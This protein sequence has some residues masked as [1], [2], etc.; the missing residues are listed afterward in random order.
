MSEELAH[1]RRR[2]QW[3]V[4]RSADHRR[5]LSA[6][7]RHYQQPIETGG[8]ILGMLRYFKSP[9]VLSALGTILVRTKWRRFSK[10]PRWAWSGW[11]LFQVGRLIAAARAQRV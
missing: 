1:L 11:K 9:V 2:R 6:V 3:L 8:K 10:V 5:V 7:A 4:E